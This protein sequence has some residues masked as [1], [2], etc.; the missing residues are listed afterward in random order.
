VKIILTSGAS[1]PD[2][3]VDR[4]LFRILEYFESAV[5]PEQVLTKFSEQ[6]A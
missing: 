5:E 2:S 3:L 4:V 1:C 6:H